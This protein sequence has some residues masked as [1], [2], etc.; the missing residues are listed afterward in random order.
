VLATVITPSAGETT[1]SAAGGIALMARHWEDARSLFARALAINDKST[2]ARAGLASAALMAR[3]YDAG[4]TLLWAA[5]DVAASGA[6]PALSAA[7]GDLQ[8]I[9]ATR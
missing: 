6:K 9:V 4:T 5:R 3:D 8:Q 2:R 1:L 7:I